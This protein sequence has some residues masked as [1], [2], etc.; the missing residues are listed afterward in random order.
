[1]LRGN[2]LSPS[3]GQNNELNV[4]ID[5]RIKK[6]SPERTYPIYPYYLFP[7]LVYYSTLKMTAET[8]SEKSVNVL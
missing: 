5:L 7:F 8:S 4:E 3:S 2:I 1:M 6:R